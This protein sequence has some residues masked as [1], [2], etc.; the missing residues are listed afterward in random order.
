MQMI[1]STLREC[2]IYFDERADADFNGVFVVGNQEMRLLGEVRE[3]IA[4]L[5]A[6]EQRSAMQVFENTP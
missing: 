2:E 6:R 5:E 1:I 4:V 3:A